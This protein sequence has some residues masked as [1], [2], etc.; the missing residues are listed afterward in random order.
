MGLSDAPVNGLSDYDEDFD[1]VAE[2][3]SGDEDQ[4]E[5]DGEVKGSLGKQQDWRVSNFFLFLSFLSFL[6][7]FRK[8][9][10][11]IAVL[12]AWLSGKT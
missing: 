5:N 12:S 10:L 1:S 7:S 3:H 9:V 2:H 8:R 11:T 4:H 6:S